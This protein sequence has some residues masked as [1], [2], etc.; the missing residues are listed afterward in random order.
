[1]VER[2]RAVIT[3]LEALPPE[4]QERAAEKFESWL[5]DQPWDAWLK[6]QEGEQFLD[7][8]MKDYEHEKHTGTII[9]GGWGK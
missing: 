6:G 3:A 8:L 5:S 9:E 2:L 7:D 1:M 4:Q